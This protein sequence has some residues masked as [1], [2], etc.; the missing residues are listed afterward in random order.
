MYFCQKSFFT[1]IG[2]VIYLILRKSIIFE[3]N[4]KFY[5]LLSNI[6]QLFCISLLFSIAKAGFLL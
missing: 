2:S 1:K 3:S 6:A 4:L 5:I